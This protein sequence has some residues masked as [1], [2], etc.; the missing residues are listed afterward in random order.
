[1]LRHATLGAIVRLGASKTGRADVEC[2]F[3][4][5]AQ[6][7]IARKFA[8]TWCRRHPQSERKLG[9]GRSQTQKH[10]PAA[11]CV[12]GMNRACLISCLRTC[13]SSQAV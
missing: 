7:D 10:A 9:G 4:L 6:P 1:M 12:Y 5:Y 8:H 2:Q 11:P 3:L 13:A